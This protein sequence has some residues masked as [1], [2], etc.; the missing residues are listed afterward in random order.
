[1]PKSSG[2]FH[3]RSSTKKSRNIE[4]REMSR[5]ENQQKMS[6]SLEG[7]KISSNV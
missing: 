6:E 4:M 5:N 7:N 2:R 1:M 3:S